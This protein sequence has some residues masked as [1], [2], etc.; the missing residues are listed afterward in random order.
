MANTQEQ[1]VSIL[2]KITSFL[3]QTD[4]LLA[5]GVVIIIGML[6]I[7][8]PTVLLDVAIA[9]NVAISLGVL[10]IV[11][12]ITRGSEL[13]VFPTLLLITTVFRLAINVSSTRLILSEGKDFDGQIIKAFG[14]FVVQGNHVIGFIIFLVL[15]AVQFIVIIKG[16]TRVSEVAAR[17]TLDAMPGKQM[18]IDADLNAGLI[19]EQ[20]AV[21]RR[22]EI[23]EEVDFYGAMDG[24]SKFVQ[25]DVRVGLL[26]TFINII[27]GLI[28]GAM[29]HSMSLSESFDHYFILTVGDGLSAQIPSLLLSTATGIIVTRAVSEK[30]LGQDIAS[31]LTLKPKAIIVTGAFLLALALLPG[32]PKIPLILIGGIIL[33]YGIYLTKYLEEKEKEE[34]EE[35]KKAEAPTGPENVVSLINVEPIE[36]EIG[37]NLVPFVDAEQGGDLLDRVKLIRKTCALDLGLLVPPIRIRDNMKLRPSD[38]S[39]KIK[40]VEVGKGSL[41]VKKLLAIPSIG[42]S[43]EI[44]GEET[45]EPAFKTK[46]KWISEEDREKAESTG[47]SV[48]DPPSIIATHLTEV[49]KRNSNDILG[50]QEVKQLLDNVKENYSAVVEDA[51]KSSNL[52]TIQKVLQNLLKEQISIRN[53]VSILEVVADYGDRIHNIDLLTEYVRQKL[54]KQISY[55]YMDEE[56]SMKVYT[57]DPELERTLADSLQETDEGFI[58]TLDVET[59]NVVIS[60]LSEEMMKVSELGLQFIVLCSSEIR[61]LVKSMTERHL[62][63]LVVLSYSEIVPQV[64]IEQ[65]GIVSLSS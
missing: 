56:D 59:M 11:M 60:K 57:L 13:S 34:E 17:F 43:D 53:M 5:A 36:I 46:A 49:I 24:A 18:S 12:Y 61:P 51:L 20:E 39:I 4:L 22:K 38:Y 63:G 10:L 44:E 42:V 55:Q 31:Q 62:P 8:I 15:I 47:Y 7:P 64:N 58:S 52:G 21:Q 29:Y 40:G 37:F 32:F 33:A 9:I 25:G 23:R 26:I 16:A 30:S 19:T 28:V 14:D 27:G 3:K 65:L 2:P 6:I 54:A 41:R 35:I 1:S 50:R 48:V 45:L